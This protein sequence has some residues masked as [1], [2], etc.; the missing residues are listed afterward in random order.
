MSGLKLRWT[1]DRGL[2]IR[3]LWPKSGRMATTTRQLQRIHGLRIHQWLRDQMAACW[4]RFT[5]PVAMS[6]MC[7]C[8]AEVFFLFSHCTPQGA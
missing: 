6:C 8:V 3:T 5:S 1:P 4:A 2:K 7:F